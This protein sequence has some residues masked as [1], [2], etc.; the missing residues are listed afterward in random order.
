VQLHGEGICSVTASVVDEDQLPR[1]VDL[2]EYACDPL[3]ELDQCSLFIVERD[4]DRED[5]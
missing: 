5:G 4:D 1:T 3:V 2:V